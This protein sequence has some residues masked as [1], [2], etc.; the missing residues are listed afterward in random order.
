MKFI[1]FILCILLL[2]GCASPLDRKYSESTLEEDAK[3]I[4]SKLDSNDA[5]LLMGNLIRLT[6][7]KKDMTKMTY[8]EIIEDGKAWKRE[9][10]KKEASEKALREKAELEEADRFRR[11]S[12]AVA[13]ACYQKGY[14][15]AN[16]D[17]YITYAF[18]IQNKSE[19]GIR[20][21]KGEIVFTDLF[22]DEI[23]KLGFTY[24]QPIG[25]NSTVKW[26]ATSEYN[27]FKESDR[28]LKNKELKDIK[29]IWKPE[30]I[31]FEDGS[32]LE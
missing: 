6:M 10:E 27:Q 4:K 2:A 5:N 18:A 12:E 7:L 9:L 29:V 26:N 32:T 19:K 22:D 21:I 17:D 3:A 1:P 15:T 13:V 25:S 8:R 30:K 14:K 28:S 31:I 24:D 23:S 20:A 11:L 16:Y